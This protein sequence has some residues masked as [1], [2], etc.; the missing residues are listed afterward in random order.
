VSDANGGAE[1]SK[2][3]LIIS[4]IVELAQGLAPGA[5]IPSERDLA[6]RYGASRMTLRSAID[7]LVRDGHLVRRHGS[8]TYVA[9]PKIAKQVFVT[10]FTEDMR[11]RGLTASTRVQSLT[12]KPAGARLG[13]RLQVSPE[14]PIVTA[15]RL[16]LA[17]GE[18][19]AIEW[20]NVPEKLAP[21]LSAA[22]LE[23]SFYRLLLERYGIV[24]EGG[25][26]TMEPTV[27]DQEESALLG[28]PLHS[29]ALL[30]ERVTWTAERKVIEFVQTL[31]RGDR[32]RFTV[33][34]TRP[35]VR[36]PVG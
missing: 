15:E 4:R 16:R 29:P 1:Q 28:I 19:M 8:G 21:G 5:A 10:S 2:R 20:L 13:S 3:G 24:I 17:D 12:R 6:L 27:T 33:E 35:T 36:G 11:S 14:E 23:G 26:Q 18:P 30:V 31:Y 34:L 7:D 9:K 25:E 22:D 32:Y